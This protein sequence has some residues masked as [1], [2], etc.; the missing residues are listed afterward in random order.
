MNSTSPATW[1]P[2][3]P[4]P[5]RN[6]CRVDI[7]IDPDPASSS[8]GLCRDEPE[9]RPVRAGKDAA[10]QLQGVVRPAGRKLPGA[11]AVAH[12]GSRSALTRSCKY[13]SLGPYTFIE[14]QERVVA[15]VLDHVHR[16]RDRR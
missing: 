4:S 16:G 8:V 1:R 7:D 2:A 15:H 12:G 11:D 14:E 9:R 5:S 6:G 13:L 3:R 10:P